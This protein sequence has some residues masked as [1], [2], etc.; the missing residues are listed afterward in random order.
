M[1]QIQLIMILS[2][3]STAGDNSEFPL[4]TIASVAIVIMGVAG[5]FVKNKFK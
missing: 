5:Y 4:F 3:I 2:T 1:T